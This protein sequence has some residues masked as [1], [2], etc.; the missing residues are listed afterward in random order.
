MAAV[1][2][3]LSCPPPS[4]T[5]PLPAFDERIAHCALRRLRH[6]TLALRAPC[7]RSSQRYTHLS[8]P[9]HALARH[10]DCH[11]WSAT[12]WAGH[13]RASGRAAEHT[14]AAAR[15]RSI[16]R[17]AAITGIARIRRQTGSREVHAR[18]R[19]LAATQ[20]VLLHVVRRRAERCSFGGTCAGGKRRSAT[21]ALPRL[22]PRYAHNSAPDPV[23]RFPLRFASSRLVSCIVACIVACIASPCPASP[24][25]TLPSPS[26][27]FPLAWCIDV[28][29]AHSPTLVSTALLW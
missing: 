27:P 9:G 6:H 10:L 19:S 28:H 18:T 20:V 3:F 26:L 13:P 2:H 5:P 25:T 17:A 15:R 1:L 4:P 11:P 29:P 12:W 22:L 14:S 16:A 8:S 7:R 21:G 23:S 24:T